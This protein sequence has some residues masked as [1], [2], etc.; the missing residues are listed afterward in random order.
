MTRGLNPGL[1]LAFLRVI[2]GITF[3]AHGVP[4]LTGGMEGTAAFF[5]SLG[6]PAP[7]LAAWAIALLETGGGILLVVGFL[8]TPIAILL[9]V[10]M[11]VG[12]FLV[13]IPN[14]FY[15]IGP[16]QN[17]VELNLLLVAALATLVFAGPGAGALD[18]RRGGDVLTA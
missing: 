2:V 12:I 3:I 8:V 14:G 5:G 15:V 1:G 11:T 10:H 16:G 13:H 18:A 17:G 4:K 9:A 7:T 6:I